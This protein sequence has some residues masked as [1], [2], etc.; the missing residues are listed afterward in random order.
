MTVD[1]ELHADRLP[2]YLTRFVGRKSE[3][4]TVTTLLEKG[5]MVTLCGVG[6]RR[7]RAGKTRLAIEAAKRIRESPPPAADT[8]P[9][10]YWVPLGAV[11]DPGRGDGGSSRQRQRVRIGQRDDHGVVNALQDQPALLVLDNCE[12]VAEACQVLLEGLL[13]GCPQVRVLATSRVPLSSRPARRSSRCRRWPAPSTSSSIAPRSSRPH[14]S[15]PTA[16]PTRFATSATCCTDCRWQSSWAASSDP[17]ALPRDLLAQLGQTSDALSSGTAPVAD[18]HRSMDVILQTSWQWL[19]EGDRTVL[20][21]LAVFVG[22]F[23]RVGAA[24]VAGATLGSLATLT[25]R[26]LIQRLPD[27]SGG[28]RYVMHELVRGHALGHLRDADAVRARHFAH[29]LAVVET[30]VVAETTPVEPSWTHP[31]GPELG[32]IDAALLWALDHGDAEGALR[33]ASALSAFW[34]YSTPTTSTRL[35]RIERA[36]AL[37]WEPTTESSIRARAEALDMAG[38]MQ[39]WLRNR[40]ELSRDLFD[41]AR[42]LFAAIGDQA[43]TAGCLR[44]HGYMLM[45]LG[46]L[47]GCRRESRE[48]LVLSQGCGDRQGVAWG[49][50]TLAGAEL[51]GKDLASAQ[52]HFRRALDLFALLDS[53]FG[54][55]QCRVSLVDACR[56]AAD[57]TAALELSRHALDDWRTHGFTATVTDLLDGLAMVAAD[58]LRHEDAAELIGAAEGWRREYEEATEFCHRETFGRGAAGVRSRMGQEAWTA[59]RTRGARWSRGQV[60]QRATEVAEE[61]TIAVRAR[62]AGLTSREVEVL[63][64]VAQ[65]LSNAAIADQLVV[66]RRTVHA[67]LRSIFEKL[68]V[69]TRAA[70]ARKAAD[71][72]P[73]S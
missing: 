34:A 73:H 48:S 31:M 13:P 12:Q 28:S 23:T 25:E 10:V 17:G 22:G 68:G 67:H 50:C 14:T 11:T 56:Q 60:V 57:W 58:F 9:E 69:T 26:A 27:A 3:I 63:R 6:G 35:T 33:M 29:V 32:N 64:L 8:P 47:D 20:S 15:A 41:E 2:T 46:D 53:P 21:A 30:R 51:V 59:A 49:L 24:E 43:R 38:H 16:T 7:V 37:P 52:R 71:L 39:F 65:G 1:Q 42:Q 62:P 4:E 66:S 5:R 19:D 36:L 55:F 44:D 70:A 40:N 54:V 45:V 72:L 61:L 18:R